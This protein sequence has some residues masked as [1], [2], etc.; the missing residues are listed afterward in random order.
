[1]TDDFNFILEIIGSNDTINCP[2][3]AKTEATFSHIGNLELEKKIPDYKFLS[4]IVRN[5]LNFGVETLFVG[6]S[7]EKHTLN[8]SDN[9]RRRHFIV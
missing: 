8:T 6:E 5:L 3:L 2:I 1:M 4:K 7:F 9:Y